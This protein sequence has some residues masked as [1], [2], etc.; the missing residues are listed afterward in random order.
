MDPEWKQKPGKLQSSSLP[1][2]QALIL[3]REG[4]IL[5]KRPLVR[6]EEP[7]LFG[8]FV[9]SCIYETLLAK[10]FVFVLCHTPHT[11]Q[12][13]CASSAVLQHF[14]ALWESRLKKTGWKRS[15]E[16]TE[17]QQGQKGPGVLDPGLCSLFRVGQVRLSLTR[18]RLR[19]FCALIA[20]LASAGLGWQ[21]QGW[22]SRG[23][24]LPQQQMQL[25]LG[26]SEAFLSQFYCLCNSL[27][28]ECCDKEATG[29]LARTQ[30]LSWHMTALM[31]FT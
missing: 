2:L 7:E 5:F 8:C 21:T 17:P 6:F 20:S 24:S 18:H 19:P 15:R 10:P 23:N 25:V 4:W 30:E 22:K 29:D 3:H 1:S 16:D 14:P 11:F 27:D 31:G 9:M 12:F 28:D 13:Y 26:T